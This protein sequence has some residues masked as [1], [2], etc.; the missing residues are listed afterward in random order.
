[1]IDLAEAK[2][3]LHFCSLH[4]K[5]LEEMID[6]LDPDINND[7]DTGYIIIANVE[8]K[9]AVRKLLDRIRE[10]TPGAFMGEQVYMCM[11]TVKEIEA[12]VNEL[13]DKGYM[14]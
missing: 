13:S 1:M 7:T 10:D 4:I 11:F 12:I 9:K 3:A 14:P 6:N 2:E 8:Y 5:N